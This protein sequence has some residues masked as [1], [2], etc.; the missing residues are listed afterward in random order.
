MITFAMSGSQRRARL[1]LHAA[2]FLAWALVELGFMVAAVVTGGSFGILLAGA[3][4]SVLGLLLL[5]SALREGAGSESLA[6][7]PPYLFHRRT[8]G[9]FTLRHRYELRRV[10]R[11]RAQ[12]VSDPPM[13]LYRVEFDY[14]GWLR[15]FG[16]T[17]SAAEAYTVVRMIESAQARES[18]AANGGD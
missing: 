3:A 17:L 12:R 4:W 2:L 18:A 9:P 1:L 11:P 6:I 13:R 7:A 16:G 8:F 10:L 5:M 15:R 14:R